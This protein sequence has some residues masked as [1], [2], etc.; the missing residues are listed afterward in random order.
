MEPINAPQAW[1]VSTG[2]DDVVV[3]V[4]DS[5][6]DIDHPDLKDNIWL[7]KNEIAGNGRDDDQ[8][9][10][11]DDVHGWNFVYG[12]GEVRP[13]RSSNGS[14]EAYL[15]G[16]AVASLVAAKGNDSIGISGV[17]WNTRIMPLVVLGQDGY[18]QDG[19]IINAIRYAVAHGADIINLSF[20]GSDFNQGLDNAISEAA[21]QGVLVV[22]AAG[23][24]KTSSGDNLDLVPGYPACDKGV[25]G[26][27]VL[28]VSSVDQTRRRSPYANFG[29]CVDLSA[30]GYDIFAARPVKDQKTGLPGSGYVGELNGT[31][32]AAPLVS[33]VAALLKAHHPEWG[34]IEL[35]ERLKDTASSL[36]Q[37]VAGL[38][39]GIVDAA[40]ALSDDEQTESF[41]PLH[42]QAADQGRSPEV[43]VLAATGKELTRFSVGGG[44]DRRGLRAAFVRWTGNDLP[45]I[46]VVYQNDPSGLWRIFSFDGLLLAA[47]ELGSVDGG[48]YLAAQDLQSRGSDSLFM[49]ET[50]GDRAW[51][52]AQKNP[53]PQSVSGLG[54]GMRGL[55]ALSVN[56]PV[57]SF[58]VAPAAGDGRLVVLGDGGKVLSSG[59]IDAPRSDGGWIVRRS[60]DVSSN[61]VFDLSTV[62]EHLMF[63]EDATGLNLVEGEMKV[64]RWLQSP[65]GEPAEDGWRLFEIW[66]R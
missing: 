59:N 61:G 45:E 48:L 16:T 34:A 13:R 46:A 11:I 47:G 27:G 1:D 66:P 39:S 50:E 10:H 22:S 41:G 25:A 33:G 57:P 53:S 65:A 36:P 56:R 17:A 7:N 63:V 28:T 12:D 18:G 8:D 21:A 24:G 62:G 30:P 2:T 43:R 6:I 64:S 20:V 58:L 38:G 44:G 40:R 35:A 9:G 42:L 52:V 23:N 54:Q 15:H 4:I 5:G 26:R 14:K 55:V 60:R 49:G 19:D 51:L 29:S 31:S 32:L 3:A 37:G